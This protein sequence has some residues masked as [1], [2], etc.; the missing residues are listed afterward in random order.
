MEP[1]EQLACV[2]GKHGCGKSVLAATV[3]DTFAKRKDRPTFFFSFSGVEAGAQVPERMVCNILWQLLETLED[4][5]S[6]AIMKELMVKGSPLMAEL[7]GALRKAVGLA[8]KPICCIVDG[9]DECK[10]TDKS[11]ITLIKE[12]LESDSKLRGLLIGRPHILESVDKIEQTIQM[13]PE[14]TQPEIETFLRREIERSDLFKARE[15]RQHVF[16]SIIEGADGMFLWAKLMINDLQRSTSKHEVRERLKKLPRGLAQAYRHLLLQLINELDEFELQ[17]AQTILSLPSVSYRRLTLNEVCYGCALKRKAGSDEHEEQ[18]LSDYLLS[19]PSQ[20]ISRVC[21]GLIVIDNGAISLIH[22]SAKEYLTRPES[23]WASEDDRKIKAFRI[24]VAESNSTLGCLCID[25]MQ[26][27]EYKFSLDELNRDM[28]FSDSYPFLDYACRYLTHHFSQSS[29]HSKHTSNKISRF[30]ESPKC[31]TWVELYA[32]LSNSEHSTGQELDSLAQ[33]ATWFEPEKQHETIRTS[34]EPSSSRLADRESERDKRGRQTKP[35][36]MVFRAFGFVPQLGTPDAEVKTPSD[37]FSNVDRRGPKLMNLLRQGGSLSTSWQI[38]CVQSVMYSKVLLARSDLGQLILSKSSR[39]S[40]YV[41]TMAGVRHRID[42]NDREALETF[43]AALVKLEHQDNLLKSYLLFQ[44]GEVY[45]VLKQTE[46]ALEYATRAEPGIQK[47]F[48]CKHEYT[49]GLWKRIGG[50]YLDLKDYDHAFTWTQKALDG[51][52]ASLGQEHMY[53]MEATFNLGLIYEFRNEL[54]LA[55]NFMGQA[56]KLYYKVNGENDGMT[57][58]ATY[59]LGM[60]YYVKKDDKNALRLLKISY[61][62]HRRAYGEQDWAAVD[63]AYHVGAIYYHDHSDKEAAKWYRIAF[64][65]GAAACKYSDVE[66]TA[67]RMTKICMRE[68]LYTEAASWAKQTI[69]LCVG[70]TGLRDNIE[71]LDAGWYTSLIHF[72]LGRYEEALKWTAW[73]LQGY[74]ARATR[75]GLCNEAT[76]AL[77]H[78]KGVLCLELGRYQEAIRWLE[79]AYDSQAPTC[80]DWHD[81]SLPND[82][83]ISWSHELIGDQERALAWAERVYQRYR[84]TEGHRPFA[85]MRHLLMMIG[86]YGNPCLLNSKQASRAD[87]L[88]ELMILHETNGAVLICTKRFMVTIRAKIRSALKTC[89]SRRRERHRKNMVPLRPRRIE[90]KKTK[91]CVEDDLT[92]RGRTIVLYCDYGDD[93]VDCCIRGCGIHYRC[94]P[95]IGIDN[96]RPLDDDDSDDDCSD[97]DDGGVRCNIGNNSSDEDYNDEDDDYINSSDFENDDNDRTSINDHS[98]T[99]KQT[100][101]LKTWY[102]SAKHTTAQIRPFQMKALLADE[103]SPPKPCHWVRERA[104]E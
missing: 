64:N 14:V 19:N 12:L 22:F 5:Q 2:V 52:H 98:T 99:N 33:F 62:L 39:L 92:N 72:R 73:V 95:Y 54:D 51:L 71:A 38:R 87:A 70:F 47:Y 37:L 80:K 90:K 18:P 57:M 6:C 1:S 24:D 41:L 42:G 13:S 60:I 3:S 75:K 43:K 53:A 26:N 69:D 48:G 83:D 103:L 82:L 101:T 17:L 8:R 11:P 59:R 88:E 9:I 86:S 31:M 91:C 65:A 74:S 100:A 30:I 85:L 49:L 46:E 23:D 21:R 25:Y 7:W 76:L 61:Q 44:T 63:S 28:D 50:L 15:L 10:Y 32:C 97:E 89:R 58:D 102:G 77:T 27:T 79:K 34:T 40:P 29:V 20:S 104:E 66:H 93:N 36:D 81:C 96:K 4:S 67:L 45:R 56:K 68:R 16:N 94:N 55:A 84:T 78:Q 35:W